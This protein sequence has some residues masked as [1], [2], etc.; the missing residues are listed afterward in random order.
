[1]SFKV[2]LDGF[3]TKQQARE[4]LNWYENEGEQSFAEC[5]EMRGHSADDGC[6]IDVHRQGNTNMFYD[7]LPDGYYA[8]VK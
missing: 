4:F 5:L 1:M 2:T 8:K 7:A 6:M 3:K